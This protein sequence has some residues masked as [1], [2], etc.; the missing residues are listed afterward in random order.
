MKRDSEQDAQK[1]ME[2]ICP[3]LA[4]RSIYISIIA[5]GIIE[6]NRYK[7]SSWCLN[8]DDKGIRLTVNHYYVCTIDKVGIW[9]ALDDDFFHD[10][11]HFQKHLPTIRQLSDWGW[12]IDESNGYP[13]YKDKSRINDFSV[14]GYYTVGENHQ[15]AWKHIRLLF[16]RL[17]YKAIYY[18]QNMDKNTP[19]KH[20]SGFLKYARNQFGIEVPDPLYDSHE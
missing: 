8:M 9:L 12:E 14:N 1:I 4:L 16:L 6:A 15:V 11:E 7:R 3:S 5:E 13:N 10:N 19:A 20:S 2:T 18:G 17:I